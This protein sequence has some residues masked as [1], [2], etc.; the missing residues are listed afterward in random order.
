MQYFTPIYNRLSG[1]DAQC[2][3]LME[4]FVKRKK[5]CQA[6]S[7]QDSSQQIQL[8]TLKGYY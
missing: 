8:V 3:I 4:F 6:D 1:H 2:L 5:K 7:K